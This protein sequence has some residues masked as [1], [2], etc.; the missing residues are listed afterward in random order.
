MDM[1]QLKNDPNWTT[2][3]L[4]KNKL[5]VLINY[6]RQRLWIRYYIRRDP[7]F[8]CDW[9]KAFKN[10]KKTVI[11]NPIDAIKEASI[12]AEREGIDMIIMGSVYLVGDILNY[13]IIRDK[14]SLWEELRVHW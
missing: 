5:R 7:T 3:V 2:Y 10:I 1:C 9:R 4:S 14:L 11:K 12:I 8:W 6:E 13:I